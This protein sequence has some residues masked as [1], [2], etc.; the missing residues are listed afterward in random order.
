[1]RVFEEEGEKSKKKNQ[2]VNTKKSNWNQHELRVLSQAIVK[3][4]PGV[5]RRWNR[6]ADMLPGKTVKDV[7]DSV[8][9]VHCTRSYS[10]S[11][12]SL[13][14]TRLT[15][16]CVYLARVCVCVCVC[17]SFSRTSLRVWCVV[18]GVWCV[19]CVSPP[20]A[21]RWELLRCKKRPRR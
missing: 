4:P 11:C 3:F 18:C 12:P 14:C 9:H 16:N 6:I 20:C 13:T 21:L 8:V 17:V 10:N 19:S 15:S 1:V 2:E 5:A 7:G